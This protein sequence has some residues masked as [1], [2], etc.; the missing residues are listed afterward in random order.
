MLEQVQHRGFGMNDNTPEPSRRRWGCVAV[1]MA[2]LLLPLAGLLASRLYWTWQLETALNGLVADGLARDLEGHAA[3]YAA[4]EAARPASEAFAQHLDT[5]WERMEPQKNPGWI[6]VSQPMIAANSREEVPPELVEMMR[7]ELAPVKDALDGIR[8]AHGDIYPIMYR[9]TAPALGF[10]V[11]F[12]VRLVLAANVLRLEG[13]AAAAE[14][15]PDRAVDV[16]IECLGLADMLNRVPHFHA[17]HRRSGLVATALEDA[18]RLHQ[19]G[20]LDGGRLARLEERLRGMDLLE[21]LAPALHGECLESIDVLRKSSGWDLVIGP[22]LGYRSVGDRAVV[23]LMMAGGFRAGASLGV[24]RGYQEQIMRWNQASWPYARNKRR[25]APFWSTFLPDLTGAHS[26]LA[27]LERAQDIL[28]QRITELHMTRIIL[29]LERFRLAHVALPDSLD[30]LVPLY[31]PEALVDPWSGEAFRYRREGRDYVLY[32]VGLDSSDDGGS[33]EPWSWYPA[34]R[35]RPSGHDFTYAV[36]A[37][38]Q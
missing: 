24:V 19:W 3:K 17:L 35:Q 23:S 28:V 34:N 16:L 38:S 10:D 26:Q 11:T 1:I 4:P 8:T 21:N 30:Q 18:L 37:D 36:R 7:A 22:Q 29:A 6:S 32:S 20:M 27:Q 2:I 33:E 5:L 12:A 14:G 31:L 15:D 9:E 25:H 13:L